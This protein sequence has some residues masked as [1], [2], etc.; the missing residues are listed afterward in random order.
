MKKGKVCLIIFPLAAIALELLPFGVTMDFAS[1]PVETVTHTYSYFSMMPFGYGNFF[2]LIT[3]VLSCI[4]FVCSVMAAAW[5]SRRVCRVLSIL[6][7]FV[8]VISFMAFMVGLKNFSFV[9]GGITVSLAL[10]FWVSGD[11]RSKYHVIGNQREL[12]HENW[13][14]RN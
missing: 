3:A 7:A 6:S 4:V 5:K 10:E 12:I 8:L 13:K 11:I 1:S 9:G 14:F 2:P